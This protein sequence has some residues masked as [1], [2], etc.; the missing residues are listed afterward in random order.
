MFGAGA[1]GKRGRAH[2]GMT[3]KT[4]DF[5]HSAGADS[6]GMNTARYVANASVKGG[7]F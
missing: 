4:N 6:S 1:G 7:C 3:G 2:P 5:L